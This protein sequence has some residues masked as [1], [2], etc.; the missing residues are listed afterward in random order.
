MRIH[1]F[2]KRPHPKLIARIL[3]HAT[4]IVVDKT[5]LSGRVVGSGVS[6]GVIVEVIL[7]CP[8]DWLIINEELS[9]ASKSVATTSLKA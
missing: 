5:P 6:L 7:A 1:Y 3:I 4:M 2:L 8:E 9:T